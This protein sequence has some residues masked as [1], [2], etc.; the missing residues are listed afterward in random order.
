MKKILL[1]GGLGY[2]GSYF[3]EN[4]SEKY[5]IKIIDTNYFQYQY[6]ND[7]NF[8]NPLIKDTRNIIKEDINDIDYI[9]HM[10]ELSNDPLGDLNKDL[11]K[12][13]NHVAT[14]NLL[15]LANKSNIKKF[16]YMSSA[17]V[18][19]FSEEIMD[20]SSPVKPL[21][22]Y[23]KAKVLN[24]QYI[25]QNNFSFE[26]VILRNSTAFGFSKNLR[27]DLVV[28]DLTYGGLVNNEINLL[29]DGTPRRP[30]VHIHDICNTIHTV[31]NDSRNLDKEVFN[32]GSDKMNYSIKDIAEKI[33]ISL[34][35]EQITFGKHD[36][37]QRSYVLNFNKL[38]SFFPNF[39]IKYTLEEGIDDL[40]KNL[41]RYE[42]TGS[43]KRIKILNE[44]IDYKKI[45]KN[46][47]WI[48]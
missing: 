29:S 36:S 47:Y 30:L 28:N 4:Y 27:L 46:L 2:I 40:V 16:I 19:G 22:E 10:G 37:D 42:I 43:E 17:S 38:N 1:T 7:K 20:E 24:E 31:I 12:D 25:L 11:T 15:E 21:T 9:V 41:K 6:K 34:N 14:K 3:V 32:V 18:Y 23:S 26:T 8:N 48:K 45:D 13:I 44:L 33:G 5:A 39:N 35:L